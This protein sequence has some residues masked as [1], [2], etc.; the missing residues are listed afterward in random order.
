MIFQHIE[1]FHEISLVSR[2]GQLIIT[3]EWKLL[4][5]IIEP[6]LCGCTAGRIV[7]LSFN[8]YQLTLVA[9]WC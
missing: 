2:C 7:T 9:C 5:T 6:Q 8:L 3:P 4:L 1:K